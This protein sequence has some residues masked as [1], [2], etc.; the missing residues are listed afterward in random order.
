MKNYFSR[1]IMLV[2]TLSASGGHSA[3]NQPTS[4]NPAAPVLRYNKP[5]DDVLK[6]TLSPLQYRVTQ[7]EATEPPFDNAYWNEKRDGIYVDVVTGEPL[8]SSKDKYDSGTGWPSFS[9]PLAKENIVE[10]KDFLRVFPR[11]EVRSRHGDS[12]LG[13]VFNDGPQ[14][15]GTRY[16]L[17][18]AALRFIP[19]TEMAAAGYG[20]FLGLFNNA[21]P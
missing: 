2:A 15:G 16:C 5:S 13:H 12:H 11:T 21:K 9:K 19:V 14:P 17:N 6:K 1:L 4:D 3:E 8:F 20:E 18:S 10:K 7:K